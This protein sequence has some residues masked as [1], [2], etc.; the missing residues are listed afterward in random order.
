MSIAGAPRTD[1]GAVVWHART[2]PELADAVRWLAGQVEAGGDTSALEA[3]VAALEAEMGT[4]QTTLITVEE[5]VALLQSQYVDLEARVAA[6]EAPAA[7]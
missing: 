3:R 2:V 7:P 1:A 6:L 5:D 4:L